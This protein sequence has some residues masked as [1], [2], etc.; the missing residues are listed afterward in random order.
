MSLLAFQSLLY[1]L[2]RRS[3]YHQDQNSKGKKS[4]QSVWLNFLESKRIL[5]KNPI[6]KI[7]IMQRLNLSIL[8]FILIKITI[9]AIENIRKA[10]A[11]KQTS[12]RLIFRIVSRSIS[13]I[14]II[15]DS[16]FIHW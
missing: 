10:P 4:K 3:S 7:I 1:F 5:P 2:T 11:L 16:E 13:A 12:Y 15:T 9:A 8:N 6:E 14:S